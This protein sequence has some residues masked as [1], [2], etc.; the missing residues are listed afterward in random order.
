MAADAYAWIQRP[1]GVYVL[2]NRFRI[3]GNP[4]TLHDAKIFGAG[5]NEAGN[6]GI[7]IEPHDPPIARM[8]KCVAIHSKKLGRDSTLHTHE[9][10]A[11]MLED[12][13]KGKAGIFSRLYETLF[14]CEGYS[15]RDVLEFHGKKGSVYRAGLLR[16]NGNGVLEL[17]EDVTVAG[18][19]WIREFGAHR[20]PIETVETPPEERTD[21]GEDPDLFGLKVG[22]IKGIDPAL[23]GIDAIGYWRIG[24]EPV[25]G[26]KRLVVEEP[27][28]SGGLF[29]AYASEPIDCSRS[30]VETILLSRGI[31]HL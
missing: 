1:G 11:G 7:N 23:S 25:K 17:V 27:D 15:T 2:G 14:G 30:N 6:C 20:Y 26:E 22:R 8:V 31:D 12:V 3:G 28:L 29:S 5:S 10:F 16:F 24:P 9:E 18:N 21:P 4:F 19:G 13:A